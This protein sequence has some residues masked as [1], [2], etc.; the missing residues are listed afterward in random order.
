MANI[1]D[2]PLKNLISGIAGRYIHGDQ[3]TMG[4]VE[5]EKGSVLPLHHHPHEQLTYILEGELEMT[6]G[7]ETMTLRQGD[8][9]VIHSNVP[10]SAV[11]HV[12]CSV[13]DVFA[14]VREEYK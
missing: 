4:I 6:I 8:Y 5:I 13:M 7:G 12:A 3:C 14:P 11:A 1:N 2:I 9:F 10:H